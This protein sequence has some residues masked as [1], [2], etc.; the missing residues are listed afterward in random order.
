MSLPKFAITYTVKNESRLLPLSIK[1]HL[2]MGCSRFYVFLD[3]TTDNTSELITNIDNVY[4][5]KT[6]KPTSE[7]E[8]PD[9]IREILPWW[10]NDFDVRKRIN[11]FIAS[12]KAY[13]DGIDWITCIDPDE[14]LLYETTGDIC[15]NSLQKM[16]Y[17]VPM[18]IDQ[19][20]MRNL[21][22]IPTQVESDNP[23][24][25]YTYFL[26]RFP[27]TEIIWRYSHAALRRLV[28]HPE[29]IAWFDHF[30]YKLRFFNA[31]PRLMINPITGKKIPGSY[32]LGYTNHKSFIRTNRCSEFNFVIHKWVNYKKRPKNT[33]KGFILHYDL[34]DYKYMS[35]KFKQREIAPHMTK[36]FYLRETI[37]AIAREINEDSFRI[38]FEKNIAITNHRVINNL[39]KKKIALKI[40]KVSEYFSSL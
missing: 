11:T 10:S 37:G 6:K 17:D 4:I 32:F 23:F 9:W 7:Q 31:L 2:A 38:F 19:L 27:L 20:L 30:Y 36:A 33:Y 3:N 8:M 15:I 22:V 21:E 35:L 12:N 24:L 5:F 16:L 34:F 40:T 18:H 39:I 25:D 1:Y 13:S 26:N 29:I 28:N 14:I